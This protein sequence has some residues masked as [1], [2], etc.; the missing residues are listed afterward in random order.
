MLSI[1]SPM[2]LFTRKKLSPQHPSPETVWHHNKLLVA[3]G[4]L[5]NSFFMR[6]HGGR[7]IVVTRIMVIAVAESYTNTTFGLK[8][9]SFTSILAQLQPFAISKS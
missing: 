7:T 1:I 5:V 8:S 3:R 6:C 2:T 4:V 9:T